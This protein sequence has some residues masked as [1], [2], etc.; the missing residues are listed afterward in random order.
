MQ[1]PPAQKLTE[2]P[3]IDSAK[4][5]KILLLLDW[6]YY[7][8]FYELNEYSKYT[9]NVNAKHANKWVKGSVISYYW[10]AFSIKSPR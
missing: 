8:S 4:F 3:N 6:F 5:N 10:I 7:V 2:L 9:N 1:T